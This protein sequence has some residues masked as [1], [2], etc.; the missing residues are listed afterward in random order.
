MSQIKIDCQYVHSSDLGE[1]VGFFNETPIRSW[2]PEDTLV[3]EARDLNKRLAF[4]K[5]SQG[6]TD[7]IST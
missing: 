2:N 4:V 1:I 3:R 5:A 6:G 7:A